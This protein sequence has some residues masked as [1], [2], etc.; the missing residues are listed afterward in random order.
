LHLT[1]ELEPAAARELEGLAG[2]E[3]RRLAPDS[4]LAEHGLV[5]RYRELESPASRSNVL[6]IAVLE[7]EGGVYLDMDTVTI[8]DL[9]A[10]RR[11]AQAFCGLEHVAFPAPLPGQSAVRLRSR[12]LLLTAMREGLFHAPAGWRQFRKVEHLFPRAANNAVLGASAHHPLLRDLLGRMARMPRRDALRRYALGTHLLQH[13]LREYEGTD[14]SVLEPTLF[15][16]LG[17]RISR[18]WFT[19]CRRPE[20]RQVLSDETRVVHW[21]ASLHHPFAGVTRDFLRENT[22][23]QLFAKLVS[24]FELLGTKKT[25][26]SAV[27]P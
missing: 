2:V 11:S 25:S 6:R 20:P 17:P 5:E 21:Y 9:G 8:R 10:L 3:I 23:R 27:M 16:P 22:E 13:A 19:P 18:H 12:G 26:L 4:L 15:Y 7:R 14:L 24:E 1:H